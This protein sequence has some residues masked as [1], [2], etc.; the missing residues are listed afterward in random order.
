MAWLS[1]LR[2]HSRVRWIGWALTLP[3]LVPLQPAQAA[4]SL[5]YLSSPYSWIGGGSTGSLSLNDDFEILVDGIP[6]NTLGF[7]I[8]RSWIP[9]LPDGAYVYWNLYLAAPQ[10]EPLT[11]GSYANA[12]RWPFQLAT[13]PG[14]DFSGNHRGNNRLTGS[15]DILE[16]NYTDG[17]ISSI[18]VD[19]L[20]Y[21]EE[22]LNAWIKGA[23]RYHSAIPVALTPE[24]IIVDPPLDPGS[25]LPDEI[26]LYPGEQT[27]PDTSNS[28]SFSSGS[29]SSGGF[30]SEIVT[31]PVVTE[32]TP[33]QGSPV[34]TPGPLPIAGA[35]AGWHSARR[36]RRRRQ[37]RRRPAPSEAN[38]LSRR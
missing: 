13:A 3:L 19:F 15:F 27:W 18:A 6:P 23:L 8:G 32:L 31:F 26:P 4:M 34:S 36:L 16:L 25:D 7:S 20:Q 17:V 33:F 28:G 11:V 29:F 14:L 1:A 21:D 22:S 30:S 12:T 10:G 24:P 38:G 35:V 5:S 9:D 37:A 2:S